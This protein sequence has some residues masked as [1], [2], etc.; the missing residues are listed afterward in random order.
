VERKGEAVKGIG[1]FPGA[2][3]GWPTRRGGTEKRMR[4]HNNPELIDTEG[5]R[6]KKK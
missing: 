4:I 5:A 2:Q 6:G 1:S 3:K